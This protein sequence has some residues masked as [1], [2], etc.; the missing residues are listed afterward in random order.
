MVIRLNRWNFLK[1]NT[2]KIKFTMKKYL[3]ILC[4]LFIVGFLS[5]SKMPVYQSKESSITE[6]ENF[7]LI[8]TDQNDKTNNVSYGV[9]DN[10]K[11]LYLKAVFHDQESLMKIMRGGGLNIYFDSSGKKKKDYKLAIERSLEQAMAANS[12][13]QEYG[14]DREK[15]RQ[16][17]SSVISLMFDQVTWDAD[18]QE[19]VFNRN[20]LQDPI[21]VELE[22]NN[23]NELVLAVK[24][25]LE[26][27]DLPEGQ[28]YFT[29]GI[30][31][32]T[33][34]TEMGG[35]PN[36]SMGG[37]RG[38]G[39]SRGGGGGG[40]QRGGSG[41]GGGGSKGNPQ[42]ASGGSSSGMSPIKIWLQVDL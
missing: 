12:I 23:R 27:L 7:P 2:R 24:I 30:E 20:V 13:R 32:N 18:G 3:R 36:G 11:D 1:S 31:T 19:F 16:N 34:S 37:S 8:S 29:M 10:N 14:T 41:G 42:G 40:G 25:P 39:Q 5:C 9:A 35:R 4:L 15:M 26:E 33:I 22:T 28:D 38:G 6:Q 21:R 17:M